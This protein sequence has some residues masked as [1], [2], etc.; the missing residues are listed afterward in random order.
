[1]R[2]CNAVC[3]KVHKKKHKKD[4]EEHI[5]LATEKHEKLFKQP[6]L[7]HED[8]PICFL[9]MPSLAPTGFKYYACC[10]KVV[11]SGCCHAPVYDNEGNKVEI[12][13]CPFCRTPTPT[14]E[15]VLIE[16]MKIRV[17]KD[18]P[19]AMYNVGCCYRNGDLGL[20]Q[21]YTKALELYHRAGRLEPHM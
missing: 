7:L 13:K 8:C 14:S 10:G 15:K 19:I 20:P 16:R 11:C 21:D 9:R 18:D 2:Y 6:P 4:C 1:M 3:K 17:E 5:R 12:E